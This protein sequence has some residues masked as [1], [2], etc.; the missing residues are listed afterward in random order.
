MKVVPPLS[1]AYGVTFVLFC[2]ARLRRIIGFMGY[3]FKQTV[4]KIRRLI[5][6][7]S[8]FI[9]FFYSRSIT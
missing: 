7:I 8:F 2:T 1:S 6:Y 3:A 4:L 9:I 5:N